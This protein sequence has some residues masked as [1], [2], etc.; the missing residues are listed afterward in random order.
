[1]QAGGGLVSR[2]VGLAVTGIAIASLLYRF[3][4]EHGAGLAIALFGFLLDSVWIKSRW[5]MTVPLVTLGSH[6]HALLLAPY[7]LLGLWFA[8]VAFCFYGLRHWSLSLRTSALTGAVV[9][10]LS[11]MA[12][13]PLGVLLLPD[14]ALAPVDRAVTLLALAA[15][16]AVLFPLLVVL[17][18]RK[19]QA[20]K[21]RQETLPDSRDEKK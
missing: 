6:G 12:G 10:V 4:A 5:M 1:M 13:E 16:W 9:G 17:V 20:K 15:E 14:A 11:Y 8:F 19:Q 2:N 21:I 18:R 7:W 3:T